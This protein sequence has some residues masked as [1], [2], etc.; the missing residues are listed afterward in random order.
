MVTRVRRFSPARLRAASGTGQRRLDLAPGDEFAMADD[1]AAAGAGPVAGLG[2]GDRD[3]A[4]PGGIGQGGRAVGE[5]GVEVEDVARGAE[6]GAEPGG[7]DAADG[8]PAA[9]GMGGDA[10]VLVL[11]R[12]AQAGIGGGDLV[13]LERGQDLGAA[14]AQHLERG[15]VGLGAVAFGLVLG[16]GADQQVAPG[17]AADDDALGGG[18]GHGQQDVAG[19]RGGGLVEDEELALARADLKA[20]APRSAASSRSPQRPAQLITARARTGPVVVARSQAAPSKAPP[21]TSVRRRSSAP[22]ASA[23]AR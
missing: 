9:V 21:V 18:G 14:V 19:E 20:A 6:G 7:A 22:F 8:D 15:A 13:A 1:A 23:W 3:E 2:L 12:R 11:G 16:G 17:G 4:R 5:T 10:V